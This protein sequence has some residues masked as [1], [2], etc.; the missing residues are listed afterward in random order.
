MYYL[1]QAKVGDVIRYGTYDQ[2]GKAGKEAID[3]IV[4]AKSGNRILVISR[5][6]FMTSQFSTAYN[7]NAPTI[8]PTV[9][10][11]SLA[12]GYLNGSFLSQAFTAQEQANILSTKVS[13]PGNPRFGTKGGPDTTD[14]VFLLSIQE[15]QQYM[16][17]AQVRTSATA[18]AAGAYVENG[19]AF[20]WLRSPGNS[21]AKAAHTRSGGTIDFEGEYADQRGALRPAMWINA[22][23]GEFLP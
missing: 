8:N 4:L 5:Y 3:W 2:D 12:R 13:T 7:P 10:S 18:S 16:S 22:N 20:W 9:W 11:T 17:P 6:C 21:V 19:E 23:Q 1:A 15:V 14:K